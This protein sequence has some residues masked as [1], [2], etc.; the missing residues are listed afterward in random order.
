MNLA[1]DEANKKGYKAVCEMY[2]LTYPNGCRFGDK[3]GNYHYIPF[4]PKYKDE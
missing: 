1:R 2:M 4:G 3:C